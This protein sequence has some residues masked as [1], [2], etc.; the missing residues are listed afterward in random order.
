MKLV[1]SV[2]CLFFPGRLRNWALKVF[3]N[4]DV[5]PEASVGLSLIVADR[6]V[7]SEGASIGHFNVLRN[8]E[9]V[10]LGE[11]AIIGTFNWVFGAPRSISS[12][13]GQP[14]RRSRL[15]MGRHSALVSRHIVDCTDAVEIGDFTTVA[16]FR[17]QIIS[18]GINVENN[19]QESLPVSIGSY[20]LI[21]TGCIILKGSVVPR[22]TVL[23]AGAV[24]MGQPSEEYSL[25]T[26]VPAKVV[27]CLSRDDAFFTRQDGYSP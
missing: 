8:L 1:L 16:G 12:F 15:S 25:M 20:C 2:V 7:I 9:E 19:R 17:S 18:H 11:A 22:G 3:L 4:Y 5:H 13:G 21:G 26:G 6:C 24:F 14:L 23:A 10:V 27:K